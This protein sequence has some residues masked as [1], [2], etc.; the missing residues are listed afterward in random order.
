MHHQDDANELLHMGQGKFDKELGARVQKVLIAQLIECPV[1][2]DV[3]I[4]KAHAEFATG[5][6]KGLQALGYDMG[7]DSIDQTPKRY[8]DMM[9]GELTRGL[10]YDFFPKCTTTEAG[11]LDEMVLQRNLQ[12]ISLCEHHLQTIY[13]KA[14]IAYIPKTKLLGLSKFSR[15]V[16][17]FSRRPQVQERLTAQIHAALVYILETEDVAVVVDAEHFCMKAR[18]SLQHDATTQ[19]N[20]LTGRFLTVP[21]LRTEFLHAIR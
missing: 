3:S 13:G 11:A 20:K 21:E 9:V 7:N 5:I 14:H 16:E 4:H 12:V 1:V 8:A 19:T 15:V 18:G 10:S 6:W 17:F 2:A